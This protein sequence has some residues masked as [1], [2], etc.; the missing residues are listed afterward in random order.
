M[1]TSHQQTTLKP[2]AV[3]A[4]GVLELD[5]NRMCN[6]YWK[7]HQESVEYHDPNSSLLVGLFLA[8]INLVDNPVFAT[9]VEYMWWARHERQ[10]QR[11]HISTVITGLH[12]TVP[13]WR[14]LHQQCYWLGQCQGSSVGIPGTTGLLHTRSRSLYQKL[15]QVVLYKVIGF[16]VLLDICSRTLDIHLR[17]SRV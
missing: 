4:T 13:C 7:S 2:L 15:V 8:Q 1:Q 9:A 3:Y 11:P 6:R 16:Q 10:L 5:S 14:Q 12:R 17:V